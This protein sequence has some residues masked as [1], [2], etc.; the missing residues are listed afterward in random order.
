MMFRF[1]VVAALVLKAV[2]PTVSALGDPQAAM[3]FYDWY[4]KKFGQKI[5]SPSITDFQLACDNGQVEVNLFGDKEAQNAVC[6]CYSAPTPNV[7]CTYGDP[8]LY[9]DADVSYSTQEWYT[10][11]FDQESGQLQVMEYCDWCHDGDCVGNTTVHDSVCG[12][13]GF[14]GSQ[15]PT[16][17]AM[18]FESLPG[19]YCQECQVCISSEGYG[20]APTSKDV[21]FTI[22]DSTCNSYPFISNPFPAL[23][24]AKETRGSKFAKKLGSIASTLLFFVIGGTICYFLCTGRCPRLP[25]KKCPKLPSCRKCCPDLKK[26]PKLPSCRKCCP[27]LT[28]CK[29]TN[30]AK[31]GAKTDSEQEEPDDTQKTDQPD[32]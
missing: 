25:C 22:G 5:E 21:C 14:Y 2:M 29:G 3:D 12:M 10:W 17:C 16:G 7:K 30:N 31:R 23:L 19:E 1:F 18:S 32:P 4:N 11:V 26:C 9:G 6:T 13:V 20:W 24:A 28:L 15:E 27:G 8:V